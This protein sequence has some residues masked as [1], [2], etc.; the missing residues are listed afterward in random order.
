MAEATPHDFALHDAARYLGLRAAHDIED[1]KQLNEQYRQRV[2]PNKAGRSYRLAENRRE[3]SAAYEMLVQELF[4]KHKIA[5]KMLWDA[6]V[7]YGPR[8]EQFDYLLTTLP[9]ALHGIQVDIVKKK[10][11]RLRRR[12]MS[13]RRDYEG[14]IDGIP[15]Y[16]WSDLK[17]KHLQLKRETRRLEV[18]TNDLLDMINKWL[19]V[20]PGPTPDALPRIIIKKPH[21]V[22][23]LRRWEHTRRGE[24]NLKRPLSHMKK[25][26]VKDLKYL[27]NY[28][29]SAGQRLD[30]ARMAREAAEAAAAA[31]AAN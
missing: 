18:M 1:E 3:I 27:P 26:R 20:R 12:E 24:R 8:Q 11:R 23:V 19:I 5:E 2:R 22:L 10:L 9:A 17:E 16:S 21:A 29:G 14:M 6:D 31:D 15:K 25:V 7:M 13:D 28:E 4:L 30:Q